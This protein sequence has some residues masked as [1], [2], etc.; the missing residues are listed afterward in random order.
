VSGRYRLV[1]SGK[2]AVD[3]TQ[4]TV[5][6]DGTEVGKHSFPSQRFESFD[7]PV[8]LTA[9]PHTIE[10][11]YS[12]WVK[13]GPRPMAILFQTMKLLRPSPA[14]ASQPAKQ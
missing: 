7:L 10:L 4:L 2:A 9:G 1:A 6:I 14:A 8:E 11:A 3:N 13:S 12:D 5:R